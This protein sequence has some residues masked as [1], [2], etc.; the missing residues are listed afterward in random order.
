MAALSPLRLAIV[1]V[2]FMGEQHAR[3]AAA[4][5]TVELVGV[6]DTDVGR[7]D[8]VAREFDVQPFGDCGRMMSEVR[9]EALIVATSD[10][11]H[12]SPTLAA[13]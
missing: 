6:A 10:A 3:A 13:L 4:L 11:E 5:P 7:A 8:R 1:G 12:L 2:G 9:P